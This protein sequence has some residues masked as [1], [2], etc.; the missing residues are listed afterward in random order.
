[1]PFRAAGASPCTFFRKRLLTEDV[2]PDA[3]LHSRR[4]RLRHA[5]PAHNFRLR[6]S[7]AATG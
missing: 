7:G 4:R 5:V 3:T 1:M 2:A 6:M